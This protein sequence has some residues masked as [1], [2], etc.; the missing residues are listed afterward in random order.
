MRINANED[1]GSQDDDTWAMQELISEV[2][3][4]IIAKRKLWAY[5]IAYYKGMDEPAGFDCSNCGGEVFK[6]DQGE[7]WHYWCPDCG[8]DSADSDSREDDEK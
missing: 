3:Q 4:G 7:Y 8:A 5:E 6:V 2:E 1:D